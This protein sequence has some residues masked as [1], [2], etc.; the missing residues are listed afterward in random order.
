VR[1]AAALLFVAMGVWMLA[2][3]LLASRLVSGL[4]ATLQP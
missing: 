2:S 4:L 1:I 3:S